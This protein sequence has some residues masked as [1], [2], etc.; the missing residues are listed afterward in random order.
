MWLYFSSLICPDFFTY[1]ALFALD[2]TKMNKTFS[3]THTEL[4][5]CETF[6]SSRL[7]NKNANVGYLYPQIKV[8]GSLPGILN[9]F[10]TEVF[11]IL[12]DQSFAWI[13]VNAIKHW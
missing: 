8:P 1:L 12:S 3:H 7:T 9:M 11:V 5:L 2:R 4:N 13:K 6:W 10:Y